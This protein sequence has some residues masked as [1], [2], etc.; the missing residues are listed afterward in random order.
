MAT[1]ALEALLR[2][3]AAGSLAIAMV[4]GL[5]GPARRWFGPEVAYRLWAWPPL[6]G[7]GALL[8]SHLRTADA[9]PV[10]APFIALA[11]VADAVGVL[12]WLGALW[13]AGALVVLAKLAA[14]QV[15]FVR[16][17]RQGCGGPA[18]VGVIAPR[19]ILPADPRF[20]AEEHA[21]IRA[22]ELEHIRRN[23]PR[24]NALA[25][26]AQVAF[27][28]NPL[29][30]VAVEALRLDQ[31]LACD[32]AVVRAHACRRAYAGALLK[33]QIL[34]QGRA[35]PLA[36]PWPAAGTHPLKLR[37]AELARRAPSGPR[38]ALG[39]VMIGGA[40]TALSLAAWTVTCV[41]T[42]PKF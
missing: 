16:R 22:H 6:A 34:A 21:L 5:R 20:S 13:L 29:V 9:G 14:V 27:W 12:P 1:E 23:D 37:L 18:V 7:L 36:C 8:P 30:A 4:L 42:F 11:R 2:M 25:A 15:M 39:E 19:L 10:E 35:P 3:T 28:F 26:L 24:G 17:A 38:Q 40:W 33:A 32:T 31:E 41:A